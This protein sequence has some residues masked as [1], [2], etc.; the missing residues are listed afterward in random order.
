M[1]LPKGILR[2]VY[3]PLRG[4]IFCWYKTR[5]E[6]CLKSNIHPQM[7]KIYHFWK[8]LQ[9]P[10]KSQ[11]AVY[12]FSFLNCNWLVQDIFTWMWH[13]LLLKSHSKLFN[14]SLLNTFWRQCYCWVFSPITMSLQNRLIRLLV[15]FYGVLRHLTTANN[16]YPVLSNSKK[17]RHRYLCSKDEETETWVSKVICLK[18]P[19]WEQRSQ[20]WNTDL[21]SP[22]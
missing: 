10:K 18:S 21:Q 16:K 17:A 4:C 14:L 13:F 2:T 20:E 19:S 1:H 12:V 9:G 11:A 7:E 15:P 3:V 6:D 8:H 5:T 22:G